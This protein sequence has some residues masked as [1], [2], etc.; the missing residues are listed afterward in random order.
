MNPTKIITLIKC[1]HVA[2]VWINI[3]SIDNMVNEPLSGVG[4]TKALFINFS[5]I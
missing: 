4:V 5:I 2:Y 3:W 1:G